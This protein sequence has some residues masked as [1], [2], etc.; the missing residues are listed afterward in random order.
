[1][2]VGGVTQAGRVAVLA[3]V[4]VLD[5]PNR[6]GVPYRSTVPYQS[7]EEAGGL[8]SPVGYGEVGIVGI[9]VFD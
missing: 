9:I 1:M 5:G 3:G 6:K 2:C 7:T 8:H 4:V